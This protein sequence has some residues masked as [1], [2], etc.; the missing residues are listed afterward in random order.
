M[1][2]VSGFSRTVSL[3]LVSELNKLEADNNSWWHSLVRK[4]GVFFAIRPGYLSVYTSGGLFLKIQLKSNGHLS[5]EVHEEYLLLRSDRPYVDLNQRSEHKQRYIRTLEELVQ[6]RNFQ[7]VQR[8][9]VKF[10][11]EER[12]GVGLIASKIPSV[13][14]I[15]ITDEQSARNP[16][17]SETKRRHTGSIDLSAVAPD[18]TAWFYE[19]K[20]LVNPELRASRGKP[21]IIRQLGRY[22]EWI[23]KNERRIVEE[24]NNIRNAYLELQGSFFKKRIEAV[25]VITCVRSRPVLLIY[26]FNRNEQKSKLPAVLE[27]LYNHGLRPEDAMTIGSPSNLKATRF[28]S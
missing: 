2:N 13:I 28:F 21:P 6:E 27:E 14:D 3:D 1:A 16:S 7:S 24:F 20:L 8:R 22:E 25:P 15:E 19:A 10:Q 18:G 11:G 12:Q 26:G 4:K 17:S 5:C 9:I 23:M